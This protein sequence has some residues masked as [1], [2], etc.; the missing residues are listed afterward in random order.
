MH[1]ASKKTLLSISTAVG[2]IFSFYNPAVHA[3][4]FESVSE[5]T[6]IGQF[7]GNVDK[8]NNYPNLKGEELSTALAIA[9]D[10]ANKNVVLKTGQSLA[11][12]PH[13]VKRLDDG[14]ALVS[15]RINGAANGSV[16][17]VI[18]T[19]ENSVKSTY[20]ITLEEV[21]PDSGW[22]TTYANGEQQVYQFVVSKKAEIPKGQISPLGMDWGGLNRCLSNAGI[23]SWAIAALSVVCGAACAVT[24]GVGCVACLVA[25]S[26]ATGGTIG[27][28]TGKNWH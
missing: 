2:L 17:G 9:V 20:Q 4:T 10:A 16:I 27:F 24:L 28:C 3:A 18:L 14:S 5:S 13:V 19:P 26:G 21:S 7:A 12:K 1:L 15:I 25:A 23:A 11:D 8:I 22:I 6:T